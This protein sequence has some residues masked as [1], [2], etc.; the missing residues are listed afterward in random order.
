MQV[1]TQW[2]LP[3]TTWGQPDDG[4]GGTYWGQ[5][6]GFVLHNTNSAPVQWGDIAPVPLMEPKTA[7]QVYGN[8]GNYLEADYYDVS[9]SSITGTPTCVQILQGTLPQWAVQA[10]P[11]VP[12]QSVQPFFWGDARRAFYVSQ[13]QEL[14]WFPRYIGFGVSGYGVNLATLDNAA[15]YAKVAVHVPPPSPQPVEGSYGPVM[16]TVA[17]QEMVGSGAVQV[18]LSGGPAVQF[19]GK[20]IG[21]NGSSPALDMG[22]P[23]RV[24]QEGQ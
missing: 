6:S 3:R 22:A 4:E 14:E 2:E 12:D 24:Q 5:V 19:Q 16:S 15:R 20:N 9:A 18:A 23:A 17:A 1:T 7:N 8:T 13:G 10:Q 11:D 21:I